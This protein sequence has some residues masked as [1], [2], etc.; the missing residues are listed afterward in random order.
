MIRSVAILAIA[1][2][3]AGCQGSHAPDAARGQQLFVQNCAVCHGPQG[4]GAEAPALK[5]EVSRKDLTQLEE[6]IKKPAPPMPV[7]YPKPLGDQDVA[8]VAAYVESL[9]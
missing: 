3:I 4:R 8:D 7:L 2:V 5:G 9:K 1:I 6:W